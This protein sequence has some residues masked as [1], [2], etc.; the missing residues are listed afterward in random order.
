VCRLAHLLL[1]LSVVTVLA[2]CVAP[3]PERDAV[4]LTLLTVNDVYVLEPSPEGRGG[5]AR[6]ATKVREIRRERP[7]TVF[8]L[9]ETRSPR[10]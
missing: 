2:G 4:P 8:T 5:L 1:A 10:R 9:S 3:C 6:L 7:H